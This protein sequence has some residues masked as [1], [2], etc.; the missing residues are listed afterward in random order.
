MN[1]RIIIFLSWLFFFAVVH[2]AAKTTVGLIPSGSSKWLDILKLMLS[3]PLFW[4]TLVLYG[5]CA[6]LYFAALRL[7]PLS[8]L[9][10]TCLA[11]GSLVTFLLGVS[12]YGEPVTLGKVAGAVMCLAGILLMLNNS[13]FS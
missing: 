12:L 7:I 11:S 6:I 13:H 5:V 4:V 10:P 2:V 1:S 3:A 9:G 8:T